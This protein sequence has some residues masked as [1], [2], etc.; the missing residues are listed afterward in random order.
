[1]AMQKSDELTE[2][3][4]LLFEQL[5]SLGAVLWSCGFNIF[6]KEEK[7]CTS[8][9]ARGGKMLAP[10]KLLLNENPILKLFYE[11]KRKGEQFW[12]RELS[13]EESKSVFGYVAKQ[14]QA[15]EGNITFLSEVT[16]P[17][18]QITHLVNFSHGN[19]MFITLEPLPEFHEIFKRF[20]KV[21]EQTY[22]R[23]LDLQKAEAQAREAHIEAGLERVRSRAMAMQGSEELNALIGTMFS[24]LTKLD[25]VLTRS[26][27]I[28]Y[29]AETKGARWWMANSEDLSI[30]MNFFVAYTDL[31]FFNAYREG[32]EERNLKWQY[33]LEGENK[34][35]TDDFLFKET[36]LSLLPDFVIAGM[37]A[38][39][40][41]YL[42]ASFN[43]FG[44]LTLASLEPLSDGHFDI[45]LRFAK[46]FDLT[47]TR[48]N[49]LKQ[50]EASAREAQ[51][52]L[53]L[54][55]VRAR[56]MAMQKS[57]ELQET[58]LVLFQ[59]LKELGEPAEQLSIGIMN[60][61]ENIVEISATLDG[62][63]FQQTFRHS[64]DEPFVM[65]KIINA[66]KA[67]EKSL[68]IEQ[69][70]EE[71]EAYNKFR[72]QLTGSVKFPTKLQPGD[73]RILYVAFFS[74]G[75]LGLST[76][77]ERPKESLEL[78]ERFAG[79]F[80]LTY[81][82]FLDLKN[83]EAQAKEAQTQLALERVRART[84]AM[85]K[86]NDLQGVLDLLVEQLIKLDVHFEI[87]NFSN[88]IPGADWDLWIDVVT[89]NGELYS[90]YVHFPRID[91]P[92]FHRVEKNIE[93]FRKGAGDL[94]K[95]VFSKKEKDS[96][97]DYICTQTIYKDIVTQE[98]KEYIYGKPGYTWSMILL[99]DTW[100]SICRFD[101][102]PFTD[103]ENEILRRFANAFGQAYT[104]FLD[105]QKAEAQ[106]R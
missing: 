86:Q 92:Y 25:L 91:H 61:A 28:I 3:A 57:D 75:M 43:N 94:F 33:I 15:Q 46:V 65:N 64:G 88:G 66:W 29:D 2:A 5:Q 78:L 14:R 74:K 93:V 84:M 41:V 12:F 35:V 102:I 38:P 96:W 11:S 4:L 104:R 72:N 59:Q 99:K 82:R 76:T 44:N 97:Q 100:V 85:Q 53:A 52:E 32:W 79:V 68:I 105:L 50:A 23:F 7:E 69:S 51:I 42:N 6:E 71:L 55:R 49:D 80:D 36:E 56:T 48:F 98:D 37:R 58:S 16:L 27:I 47:Y 89:S 67:Q 17:P 26:V 70:T 20:G 54:E 19:L 40:K 31:P 13:A 30:P 73:R 77:N 18:S 87:A 103:E 81:T 45:L 1:M 90:N 39:E 10:V 63:Q 106:A 21:F 24:E 62:K 34:I 9:I 8:F 60:E 22:T 83:A 95:D 101:N